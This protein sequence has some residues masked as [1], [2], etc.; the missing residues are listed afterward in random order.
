LAEDGSR[1]YSNRKCGADATLVKG[2]EHYKLSSARSKAN[3]PR[4]D[5]QTKQPIVK[6]T[7]KSPEE[8]AELLRSCNAGDNAACS[9]WSLGGGPQALRMAEEKAERDCEAGSLA[10]CEERY[11]KESANEDCRQSVLR[12]ALLSGDTWY[13]HEEQARAHDGS[14]SFVIRCIHKGEP[15]TRD[16]NFICARAG[17]KCGSNAGTTQFERLADAATHSCAKR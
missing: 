7:P 10:A 1:I 13:L 8:L 14:A 9:Q 17:H 16:I 11:C 15:A 2:Y 5:A 12:T 6:P 4:S 3:K